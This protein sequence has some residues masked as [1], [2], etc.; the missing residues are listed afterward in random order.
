MIVF[1]PTAI[2]FFQVLSDYFLIGL[3]PFNPS[4]TPH[5]EEKWKVKVKVTQSCPTLCDPMDYIVHGILQARILEWVAFPFS[6]ESSRP[7]NQT[8]VS[9]IAGGFFTNWATW[10]AQ[11]VYKYKLYHFIPWVLPDPCQYGLLTVSFR[12]DFENSIYIP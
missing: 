4:S 2:V 8:G 9:Y 11:V 10:E 5:T 7:R 1:I 3:N 12:L 6:R